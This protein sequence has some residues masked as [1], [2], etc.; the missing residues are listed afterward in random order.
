MCKFG[1]LRSS[2][3]AWDLDAVKSLLNSYYCNPIRHVLD[4]D[5]GHWP[6][7]EATDQDNTHCLYVTIRNVANHTP[8]S[9]LIAQFSLTPVPATREVLISHDTYVTTKYRRLGI[10]KI[11]LE[12]K[13][14]IAVHA[15][16]TLLLAAVNEQNIP[17]HR[18]LANFFCQGQGISSFTKVH[19]FR[20]VYSPMGLWAFNIDQDNIKL[21]GKRA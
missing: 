20:S 13:A 12:A 10:G 16:C 1:E 21:S 3:G 5:I 4:L 11:L 6:A 2:C 14:N 7:V 15:N 9:D 18:V 19:E 8:A 17:E